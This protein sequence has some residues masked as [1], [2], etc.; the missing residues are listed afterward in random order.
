MTIE[1]TLTQIAQKYST[2]KGQEKVAEHLSN[3]DTDL[4][5]ICILGTIDCLWKHERI[6][7]SE[8][9]EIYKKL[10]ISAEDVSRVRQGADLL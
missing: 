1:E 5:K 7:E 9:A 8:A 3:G 6:N 4:A 2:E 10:E